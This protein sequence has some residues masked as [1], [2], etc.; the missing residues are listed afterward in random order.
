M[1][2]KKE[3]EK[4]ILLRF[5]QINS[6]AKIYLNGKE[7]S[8][9]WCDPWEVDLTPYIVEGENVLEIDVTNSLMNRMIGDSSLPQTKRYTYAYPEIVT[10]Q[11]PLI[12][13]EL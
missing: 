6:L 4:Q 13:Q 5:D 8:I 3:K 12:H 9:L 2:E 7:V 10:P 1:I 11:D